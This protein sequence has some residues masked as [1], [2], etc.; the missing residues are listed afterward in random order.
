MRRPLRQAFREAH[1]EQAVSPP[2]EQ[3][4]KEDAERQDVQQ[5]DH[6]HPRLQ[7]RRGGMDAAEPAGGHEYQGDVDGPEDGDDRPHACTT[8]RVVHAGAN[9]KAAGVQ[10]PKD[11]RGR[12]PW[13]P[14]PPGV[15]GGA[16][17]ERAGQQSQRAKEPA[18]FAR[19]LRQASQANSRTPEV[20]CP[21]GGHDEEPG[22]GEPGAGDVDVN[23]PLR[24]PMVRSIGATR[25]IAAIDAAT[26]A[27]PMPARKALWVLGMVK[28]F[29]MT[30]SLTRVPATMGK[31]RRREEVG[32]R[33]RTMPHAP[34]F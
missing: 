28:A 27:A 19:R 30:L 11:G 17:P 25:K 23:D 6:A 21:G 10:G 22:Q 26:A 15:P 8:Q 34:N 33:M 32:V 13:V 7:G 12:Q 29:C 20:H 31:R 18:E 4:C 3:Q 9:H 5:Q 2:H 14:R 1:V 16:G 24:G